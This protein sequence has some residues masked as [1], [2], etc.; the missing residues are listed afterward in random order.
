MLNLIWVNI[1]V[2]NICLQRS[3]KVTPVIRTTNISNPL[4]VLL[5]KWKKKTIVFMWVPFDDHAV[6]NYF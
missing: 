6:F 5:K 3:E 4:E 1:L 2:N